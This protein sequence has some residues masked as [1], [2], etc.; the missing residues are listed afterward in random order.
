[1]TQHP[2]DLIH[3]QT[4]NMLHEFLN[5]ITN[6][7]HLSY[8]AIILERLVNGTVPEDD[9]DDVWGLSDIDN[10]NGNHDLLYK[11][12]TSTLSTTTT[13]T[14]A[15]GGLKTKASNSAKKD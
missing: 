7:A 10:N 13:S 3:P 12:K 2:N 9:P 1:M 4:R 14:M 15:T 8:Y 11:H 6:C 5:I